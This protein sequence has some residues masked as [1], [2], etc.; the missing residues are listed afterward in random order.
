MCYQPTKPNEIDTGPRRDNVRL[1]LLLARSPLSPS[2]L[3]CQLNLSAFER[4][5]TRKPRKRIVAATP[6]STQTLTGVGS[7]EKE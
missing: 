1:A 2:A 6:P 4:R 3:A 5:T 7:F